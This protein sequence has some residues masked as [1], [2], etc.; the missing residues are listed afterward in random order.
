MKKIYNFILSTG[1]LFVLSSS[2]FA[3]EIPSYIQH[4][5]TVQ[6]RVSDIGLKLLNANKIQK[7][8]S[9]VYTNDS[10]QPKIDRS[11]SKKEIVVY[12]KKLA[13]AADDNELAA[14]LALNMAKVINGYNG[15]FISSQSKL[16]P[17]KYE[18]L[19]DKR[20][21]DYAVHAGFNPVAI[22]TYM[23]KAYPQ[24][25]GIFAYKKNKISKRLANIYEYIYVNYPYYLK[26]NPYLYSES[27]QNF[28][29][30]S[31]DNRT[32]LQKKIK[33]GSK[34]PLNYE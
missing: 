34:K 27:Y 26:D 25:L 15:F 33:S 31:I 22:I 5:I 20:A 16:A 23:N 14:M 12:D 6:K 19:F 30:F 18:I 1:L 4:N 17:K 29:L 13:F 8:I 3:E 9:F 10:N 32:M 2:V 28:L 7:R 24:K 21:V 11:I